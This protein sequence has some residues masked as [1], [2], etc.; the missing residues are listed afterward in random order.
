MSDSDQLD[1]FGERQSDIDWTDRFERDRVEVLIDM[2]LNGFTKG[3]QAL[4]W[5]CPGCGELELTPYSLWINH[6]FDPDHR[7]ASRS[8]EQ[9]CYRNREIEIFKPFHPVAEE[10]Q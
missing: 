9:G 7:K 2:D 5:K 6:G 3:S 1:L 4:A 10:N 8:I